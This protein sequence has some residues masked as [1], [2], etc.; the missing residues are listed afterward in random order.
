MPQSETE[1]SDRRRAAAVA[2]ERKSQK[3]PINVPCKLCCRVRAKAGG[4]RVILSSLGGGAAGRGRSKREGE[5]RS[6]ERRRWSV[7][8]KRGEGEATD[9]GSKRV[10]R[11][12]ARAIGEHAA[13]AGLAQRGCGGRGA[14]RERG[15]ERRGRRHHR[16]FFLSGVRRPFLWW[17]WRRS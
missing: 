6:A 4:R 9:N 17:W 1:T 3:K 5:D 15:R 13:R 14:R 12:Q 8:E 7:R 10:L 11:A 2:V 16:L